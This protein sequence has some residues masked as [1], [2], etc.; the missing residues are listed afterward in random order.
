MKQNSIILITEDSLNQLLQSSSKD[1]AFKKSEEV[2][3]SIKFLIQEPKERIIDIEE[4]CEDQLALEQMET[5][6]LI[7]K[8]LG[9]N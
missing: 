1:R 4:L 9:I 7:K 3:S 2:S 6:K 8:D 5:L